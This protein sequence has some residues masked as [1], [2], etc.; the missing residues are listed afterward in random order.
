MVLLSNIIR[1]GLGG[2]PKNR[3]PNG[4][5]ATEYLPTLHEALQGSSHLSRAK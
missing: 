1:K 4:I 2:K 3:L 5:H